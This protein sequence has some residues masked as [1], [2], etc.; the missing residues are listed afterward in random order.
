VPWEYDYRSA[1]QEFIEVLLYAI[2]TGAVAI[3]S[4][5]TLAV[6]F[7]SREGDLR[8]LVLDGP[9]SFAPERRFEGIAWLVVY[10]AVALVAA[11]AIGNSQLLLRARVMF[12]SMFFPYD[13][14]TH[15]TVWAWAVEQMARPFSPYERVGAIVQLRSGAVYTGLLGNYPVIGDDKDKDF[16]LQEAKIF[17]ADS[18]PLPLKEGTIVLLN[19]RDCI[20]IQIGA[21]G[22]KPAGYVAPSPSTR[23][24]LTVIPWA[25]LVLLASAALVSLILRPEH[26]SLVKLLEVFCLQVVAWPTLGLLR[27]RFLKA[28]DTETERLWLFAQVGIVAAVTLAV[29]GIPIVLVW[30]LGVGGGIFAVAALVRSRAAPMP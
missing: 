6:S 3:L 25:A 7:A 27:W 29:I 9:G 20:S 10:L 28:P 4:V 1:F 5:A 12:A 8:Q 24:A 11:E 26:D 21:M 17:G 13:Q 30:L 16:A 15:S 22:Q 18:K 19:T 23:I 2:L 14:W